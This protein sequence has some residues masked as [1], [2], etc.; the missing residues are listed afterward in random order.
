M[1]WT[2]CKPNSFIRGENNE[3]D[4]LSLH[5]I[6]HRF[7]RFFYFCRVHFCQIATGGKKNHTIKSDPPL[8]VI[9]DVQ[10][11]QHSCLPEPFID[12]DSL[13]IIYYIFS[14]FLSAKPA[15]VVQEF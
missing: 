7:E 12:L 15:G 1:I 2:G 4:V 10:A 14:S 6:C 5:G 8:G 9:S 3:W 11:R 13:F